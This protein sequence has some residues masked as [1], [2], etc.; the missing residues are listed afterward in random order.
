MRVTEALPA[1][2]PLLVCSM[3]L[4]VP[5]SMKTMVVL[6]VLARP[7]AQS[8]ASLRAGMERTATTTG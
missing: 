7:C 6:P 4:S 5:P 8:S 3:T 2:G 1:T